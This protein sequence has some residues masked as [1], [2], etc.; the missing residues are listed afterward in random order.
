MWPI[1]SR[2]T[3]RTPTRYSKCSGI[4]QIVT[5]HTCTGQ[6]RE[7]A[8]E[9]LVS[10][11]NP[12]QDSF[13][14]QWL[15]LQNN[16]GANRQRRFGHLVLFLQRHR[17]HRGRLLRLRRSRHRLQVH[18]SQQ[19]IL[20]GIENPHSWLKWLTIIAKCSVLFWSANNLILTGTRANWD[21]EDTLSGET[22]VVV[23]KSLEQT[24][25]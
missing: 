15:L 10:I 25:G 16:R 12:V 2:R 18:H 4:V 17:R 8:H 9:K 23:V 21:S 3:S 1:W 7:F 24:Q 22:A 13:V 19:Q 14:D 6:V 5:I 20:L 11:L